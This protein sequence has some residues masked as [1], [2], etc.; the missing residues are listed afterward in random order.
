MKKICLFISMFVA[1][2]SQAQTLSY[3]IEKENT[4][5]KFGLGKLSVWD[6][7]ISTSRMTF[8]GG[9]GGKF[10][11]NGLYV[12]ANYNFHYLDNLAEASSTENI[13][14]SSVYKPTKS[15]D[16]DL[17]VGYFYQKETEGKVRV[18]IRSTSSVTHYTYV[19]AKYNKIMGVQL[20][21]KSGFSQLT[22]PQGINVTDYYLPSTGVIKTDAGMT[23]YLQYGWLSVGPSYGKIVDVEA[24][25]KGIGVRKSQYFKRFYANVLIATKG[26]LE[27]VYYTEGYGSSNPLVHRYVLD[28]NVTMSKF[29]FNVGFETFKFNKVGFVYGLELGVMPGVK[30]TKAGNGYLAVKWGILFGKQFGG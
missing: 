17:T 26:K 3:T 23:S 6:I 8:S 22:I 7:L 2:A 15:R 21:Y 11:M 5:I 4:D 14:G 12:N 30:V 19:D 16:A 1:I 28:G 20:G 18:N 10:Y 29:G 13:R 25:F 9:V 27:D 24:D